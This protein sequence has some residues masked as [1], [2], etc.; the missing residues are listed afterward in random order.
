MKITNILSIDKPNIY[1]GQTH[2][3]PFKVGDIV[4]AKIESIE[5]LSGKTFVNLRIS[6]N[7][8]VKAQWNSDIKPQINKI[9]TLLTKSVSNKIEMQIIDKSK[10]Q[11][12]EGEFLKYFFERDSLINSIRNL[13]NSQDLKLITQPIKL[14]N[15]DISNVL[16][17]LKNSMKN[18]KQL[19]NSLNEIFLQKD[20]SE[21]DYKL[22]N[23]ISNILDSYIIMN[24]L[25]EDYLVYPLFLPFNDLNYAEIY[26]D[27]DDIRKNKENK[28]LKRLVLIFDFKDIG[29]IKAML[30][31]FEK[32]S[33][34]V[35]LSVESEDFYKLLSL[36][37][38]LLQD[39]LLRIFK[40]VEIF[41]VN[42]TVEPPE[43]KFKK[44]T[45][46]KMVDIS[47]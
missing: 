27:K 13:E 23:N 19:K 29:K 39:N 38:N 14:E 45:D 35:Y 20:L 18:M 46:I 36:N 42:E 37:K 17:V 8:L 40:S 32:S 34:T 5:G 6:S 47:I 30:L 24:K 4:K 22:V 15:F 12:L 31:S 1:K 2:S 10:L 41:V 33:L 26:L 11:K 28:L 25:S 43:I 44:D 7:L 9:L 16:E 21:T 3:F